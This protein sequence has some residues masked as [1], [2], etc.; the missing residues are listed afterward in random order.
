M[1]NS[2]IALS[3]AKDRTNEYSDVDFTLSRVDELKI[4]I[5][6]YYT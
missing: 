5:I 4:K 6:Q 2:A 1:D 3:G